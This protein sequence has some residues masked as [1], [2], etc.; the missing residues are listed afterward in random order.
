MV[1]PSAVGRAQD[2]ESLLVKDQRSSAVPH[3]QPDF[4]TLKMVP[5]RV[6]QSVSDVSRVKRAF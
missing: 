2:K 5:N 3:N 6:I 4:I 1:T